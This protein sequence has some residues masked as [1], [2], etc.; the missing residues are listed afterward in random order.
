M[1]ARSLAS[2]LRV[3]IGGEALDHDDATPITTLC[4]EVDEASEMFATSK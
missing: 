3:P 4:F 2:G 1:C